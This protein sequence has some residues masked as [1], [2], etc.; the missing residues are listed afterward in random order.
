MG[1][2]QLPDDIYHHLF[3]DFNDIV[4]SNKSV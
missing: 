2:K 1:F 3:G 4:L